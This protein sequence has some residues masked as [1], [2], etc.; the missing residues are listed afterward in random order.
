MPAYRLFLYDTSGRLLSR[1]L[2]IP[3]INDA[4]AIAK[5]EKR[6]SSDVYRAVLRD[7]DRVVAEWPS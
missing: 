5:A 3:A 7:G 2:F 1:G 4:E 6:G